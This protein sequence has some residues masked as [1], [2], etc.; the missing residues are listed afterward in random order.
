MH[1]RS[2]VEKGIKFLTNKDEVP[3]GKPFWLVWVTIERTATGAYYAG[4]TACEMT[5]DREIH[6]DINHFEHVNKM[7][8]SLKRH[9][10]VDHMDESSKRYLV[11]S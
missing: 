2:T 5:V 11:R 1:A 7:D 8:K 4:V 9:I 10:M 6:A 3:N